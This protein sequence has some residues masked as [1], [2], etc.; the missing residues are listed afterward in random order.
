M[1]KLFSLIVCASLVI[2]AGAQTNFIAGNAKSVLASNG[3]ARDTVSNTGSETWV[4]K[5]SG[6][7]NQTLSIVLS[8][9]KISGTL[10]GT[11]TIQ[12]SIDGT[13]YADIETGYTVTDVAAQTKK[14]DYDLVKYPYYRA[15]WVGTG[16]MSGSAVVQ[17]ALRKR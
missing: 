4:L 17:A 14:F 12:G 10:G 9:T 3:L 13:E 8:I 15:R 6:D 16:T 1:K 2:A 7:A 11:F 5:V